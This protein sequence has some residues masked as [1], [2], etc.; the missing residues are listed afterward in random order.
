M[1]MQEIVAVPV[2]IKQLC[3]CL[4]VSV[5]RIAHPLPRGFDV[6]GCISETTNQTHRQPIMAAP[7]A[8]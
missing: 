1:Y 6:S 5:F 4:S 2:T 3:I 7:F 8:N